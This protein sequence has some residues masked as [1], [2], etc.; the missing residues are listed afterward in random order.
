MPVGRTLRVLWVGEA[1]AGGGGS[2]DVSLR[3][4]ELSFAQRVGELDVEDVR[5]SGGRRLTV[6]SC[7]RAFD[8]DFEQQLLNRFFTDELLGHHPDV[9]VVETLCGATMDFPRVAAVL[10]YPVAVR[11]PAIALPADGS[12][13]WIWLNGALEAANALLA[14]GDEAADRAFRD[15]FPTHAT[16]VCADAATALD[17]ALAASGVEKSRFGYGH[18]A[19]GLR[20]HGLL[21][22]MQQPFAAHFAGCTQ[23]LDLAC[24]AGIFLE[25]LRREG[26]GAIGVERDPA[27]VRYACGLGLDVDEADVL[28]YLEQA[29]ERF[30]G[31][32]CSHFVE[33]LDVAG[34]ERL[35]AMIARALK[36]GGVALFVFPD[37]ESIRSQLL[38]FWRD[39]EHVR[40]YHPD[41]IELMCRTHGLASEY[42][43]HRAA[44]RRVVPFPYEP[45]LAAPL[46]PGVEAACAPASVGT[47]ANRDTDGGWWDRALGAVGIASAR[48]LRRAERAAAERLAREQARS[49]RLETQLAGMELAV[50]QLWDVNQ[51]W[52]WDDNAVLRVRK[53]A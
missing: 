2:G 44:D 27:S 50:R 5:A 18:Y 35:V 15:A 7:W 30:D 26:I 22:R 28:A 12:R 46:A 51:T 45:P 47:M 52:A 6:N 8:A 53:H 10:G 33:H 37:P 17:R 13:A 41:L 31:I 19:F 11:L 4:I 9:I 38:G 1:P 25:I 3:R 29:K 24:G 43:S 32:Y 34:V 49:G 42:H 20:D 39:P 21:F 23:V 14:S 40:F 36:P 16:R 48:R